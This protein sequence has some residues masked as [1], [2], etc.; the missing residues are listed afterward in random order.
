MADRP[1]VNWAEKLTVLITVAILIVGIIQARIYWRQTQLMKLSLGQTERSIILNMGQ[2]AIAN[3]NAKVS[4]DTLGEIKTGGIDTHKLAV[5]AGTQATAAQTTAGA[6]K[7]AADTAKDALHISERAYITL[8]NPQLNYSKHSVTLA[9]NN[10]GR[11]PS[12]PTEIVVHVLVVDIAEPLQP[13][14]NLNNAV[15]R[16][17]KRSR[18][19]SVPVG[20]PFQVNQA[21]LDKMDESKVGTGHQHVIVVAVVTYNDGFPN[22]P[23]QKSMFCLDSYFNMPMNETL[24]TPC[25]AAEY[26]PISE[27]VDGYPN[28]ETH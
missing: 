26:L 22:T 5:A 13:T 24:V 8:S 2:L 17:W 16:V 27:S 19:G 18:F 7:S 20:N 25:D 28:N 10:T 4:E 11:I 23:L 14:M 9:V 6:T 3:R 15:Q 21:A 1:R 12:G